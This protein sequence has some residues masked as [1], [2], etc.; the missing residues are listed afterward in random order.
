MV[1][2]QKLSRSSLNFGGYNARH[3][4]KFSIPIIIIRHSNNYY[5]A[6]NAQEKKCSVIHKSMPD[7]NLFKMFIL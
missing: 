1:L 6:K 2:S 4:S 7:Y 3:Q 5:E